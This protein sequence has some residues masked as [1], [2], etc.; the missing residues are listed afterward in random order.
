MSD[1]MGMLNDWFT[2]EGF[3]AFKVAN[4]KLT[5]GG[6]IR[7]MYTTTGYGADLSGSWGNNDKTVKA[8]A[9]SEGELSPDFSKNTH[10]CTLTI[11]KSVSSLIVTP[12]AR[13]RFILLR[14]DRLRRRR[15]HWHCH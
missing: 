1:W 15:K 14:S 5:A 4:G 7:I 3:G 2:N 10:E 11:P 6:E 12:A 13:R 8:L 9:F